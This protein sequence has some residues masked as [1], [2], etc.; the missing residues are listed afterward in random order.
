MIEAPVVEI[1]GEL[2]VLYSHI[3]SHGK[4]VL[5]KEEA[6]LLLIELYKFINESSS[7]N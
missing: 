3:N 4:V 5:N 6:A 1:D 7:I 2:L